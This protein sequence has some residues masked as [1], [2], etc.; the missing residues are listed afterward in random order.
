M[1]I[2]TANI[3]CGPFSPE[4]LGSSGVLAGLPG[5][6]GPL[7]TTQLR[8]IRGQQ[9]QLA[10]ALVIFSLPGLPQAPQDAWLYRGPHPEAVPESPGLRAQRLG[11][12]PAAR[13]S[14][15]AESPSRNKDSTMPSIWKLVA[16]SQAASQSISHASSS[17]QAICCP[18]PTDDEAQTK[19]L[20]WSVCPSSTTAFS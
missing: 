6:L 10:S 3:S 20:F 19:R 9:Q 1:L 2:S 4:K 8:Q 15:E 5:S 16:H 14:P 18:S 12:L 7:H 13:W 17:V 11:W